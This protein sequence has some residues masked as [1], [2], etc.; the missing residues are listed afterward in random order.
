MG[1]WEIFIQTIA[2]TKNFQLREKSINICVKFHKKIK[3]KIWLDNQLGIDYKE[4]Q[5]QW[6]V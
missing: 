4:K 5:K 1:L 3:E 6:K 2:Q